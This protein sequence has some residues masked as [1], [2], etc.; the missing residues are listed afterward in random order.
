MNEGVR[1]VSDGATRNCDPIY[2]ERVCRAGY[3]GVVG[4]VYVVQETVS[5]A[6]IQACVLVTMTAPP[7]LLYIS[8][9]KVLILNKLLK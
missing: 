4:V 1:K 9:V 5:K 2:V 7:E 6:D 8:A 3:R